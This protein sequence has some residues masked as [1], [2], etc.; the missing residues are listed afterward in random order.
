M[1]VKSDEL[2]CVCA[3]HHDGKQ[4]LLSTDKG[5][6]KRIRMEKLDLTSRNTKGYRVFRQIKSKPHG[7]NKISMVSSY[8][9]LYVY[10][11]GKLDEMAV[12]EVPFMELEQSFSSPRDLNENYFYIF[13]DMNDI[14]SVEII[15]IPEGYY[16]TQEESEQTSLFD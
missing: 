2:S 7:V 14:A 16:D 6:F 3:D 13:K 10:N 1:N 15:D 11:E 12:S 5:G 9:T 4:L 8:N